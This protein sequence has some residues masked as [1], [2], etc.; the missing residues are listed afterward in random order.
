MFLKSSLQIFSEMRTNRQRNAFRR[1][2]MIRDAK[3][4][5][6]R[7]SQTLAQDFLGAGALVAILLVGL[8]LPGVL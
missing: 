8:H 6:R 3:A 4:A 2:T 1:R 5:L 7:S